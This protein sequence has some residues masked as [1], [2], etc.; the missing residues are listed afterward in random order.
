MDVEF[1]AL[2]KIWTR[3]YN[4]EYGENYIKSCFIIVVFALG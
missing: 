2:E 1:G 4:E 3:G